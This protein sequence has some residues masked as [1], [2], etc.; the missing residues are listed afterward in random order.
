MKLILAPDS[1]K[2]SLTSTQE[3]HL[4]KQAAEKVFRD[5]TELEIHAV[6]MADGG[7][8]TVDA[9]LSLLG[10]ERIGVTVEGPAS[11]VDVLAE[12]GILSDRRTAVLEMAQAS[13]LP[14]VEAAQRK[15][16]E[17]F[18]LP[19]R[20]SRGT[21]QMIADALRRGAR[22]FLLGIGG[23]ATND[24]GMG[25][26]EALG[27]RF[28]DEKGNALPGCGASLSSIREIDCEGRLPELKECRFTVI[29]DVT[30]PLLGPTG[31]T[32]VYGPQKGGNTDVLDDL[33]AGMSNY[34][35]VLEE[36]LGKSVTG[37]PGSG[38][39]GGMGAALRGFLDAKLR[40][41]IDVMLELARFDELLENAD[42]AVTGEGRLDG[43]TVAF[44]KVAGGIRERCLKRGVP[45]VAITGGMG[46]G[47]ADFY[48]SGASV[49]TSVN[50]PMS[51]ENA[52]EA[53]EA[54]S[55]FADAAERMFRMVRIG[56]DIGKKDR[57]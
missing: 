43:Q 15:T 19:L 4:L 40:R 25:M 26:L 3:I 51:L 24:G 21:G 5:D 42:L 34:A 49:I 37:L 1:F 2:G 20:S 52:M 53:S 28:L 7:E 41:G 46:E 10:G 12:Y 17:A 48:D 23:S 50:R 13:G 16:G 22:D 31:A 35:K 33:E 18:E 47:A 57:T 55:L 45:V 38:A 36:T 6:P 44:G 32:Y 30:N 11:G 9:L 14:L 39:A 54:E 56:I 8:G 29:C 27:V